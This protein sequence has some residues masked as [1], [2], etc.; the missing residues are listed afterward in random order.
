MS[1][2]LPDH[3]A[4]LGLD[5]R[6]TP[7]QI[8][9]AYLL[10]TKKHHPDRNP[11]SAQALARTQ[12]LNAAYET[13]SNPSRRRLYERD[14]DEEQKPAPRLGR[15]D[16]N[17]VQDAHVP[18]EAFFRGTSLEVRVKDPANPAGVEKYTVEVPPGTAPGTRFRL[19]RAGGGVVQLRVKALPGFRFKARGADLRCDLRIS[20]QRATQGGSENMPGP[21]GQQIR[22]SIP[23][24][25]GRGEV[26][27]I[28]GEGLPKAR[29][30]RGDLL[31][32]VTYRPD[33]RISRVR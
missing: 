18:I 5:R 28:K 31:V 16:R 12:E 24:R 1:P 26:V 3:Y 22:V 27:R 9:A 25:I 2:R 21:A 4:T 6:C 8:R 17:I 29:G 30:G 32:R 15:I 7:A 11:D 13:L 20:A 14:L 19:P 23:A 10:L 33:V